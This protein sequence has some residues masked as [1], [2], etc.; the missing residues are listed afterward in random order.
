MKLLT[1]FVILLILGAFFIISNEKI[2]LNSKSN[3]IKFGNTYY[4]WLFGMA[5]HAKT[6][7]AKVIKADWLPKTNIINSTNSLNSSE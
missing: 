7:T 5:E 1:I 3:L 2:P 6:I 4:A